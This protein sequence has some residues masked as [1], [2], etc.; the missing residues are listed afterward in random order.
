MA[1]PPPLA[2]Q[3]IILCNCSLLAK[4]SPQIQ[5]QVDGNI[6]TEN[7]SQPDLKV[8][9][10]T[11]D[12]EVIS[13]LRWTGSLEGDRSIICSGNNSLGVYTMQFLLSNQ[14]TGETPL[15]SGSQHIPAN[16]AIMH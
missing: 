10:L 6:I 9:T 2:L 14:G 5:W 13:S 16:T 3:I 8:T 1:L 15:D 4:P 12:N 7:S 11:Q